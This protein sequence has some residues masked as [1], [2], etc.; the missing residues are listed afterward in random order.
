MQ[1]ENLSLEKALLEF[2]NSETFQILCDETTGMYMEGPAYI[3]DTYK[4][5]QRL[6][7]LRG[8]HS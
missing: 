3:Y 2:H 4:H 1:E 7:T 8:L 5:E 6:G